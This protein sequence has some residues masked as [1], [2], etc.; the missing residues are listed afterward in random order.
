LRVTLSH[1]VEWAEGELK[2]SGLNGDDAALAAAH[3]L[4]ERGE[5]G[6]LL[7]AVTIVTAAR[8]VT[9]LPEEA[10]WWSAPAASLPTAQLLRGRPDDVW[11]VVG[12]RLAEPAEDCWDPNWP[13]HKVAWALL[14]RDARCGDSRVVG[15]G[16]GERSRVEVVERDGGLV[17]VITDRWGALDDLWDAAMDEAERLRAT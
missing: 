6:P 2:R 16:E 14:P 7:V 11:A 9:R 12:E 15:N 8:G 4:T 10:A 1:L 13:P 17:A 5:D 3:I